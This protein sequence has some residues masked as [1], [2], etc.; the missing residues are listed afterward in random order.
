[1]IILGSIKKNNNI[2]F[3]RLEE[4]CIAKFEEM[5]YRAQVIDIPNESEYT[6]M[7]IDF[8]NEAT[9]KST[10]I[11]HFPA[12]ATGAC[13]TSLCLIDGTCLNQLY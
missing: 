8:T 11:R 12:S 4:Y 6:V 2:L 5:W 1:M 10:D 7:Y 3:F 9:L 13:K